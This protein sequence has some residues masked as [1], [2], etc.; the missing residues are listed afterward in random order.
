MVHL[1]TFAVLGVV[2]ATATATALVL[3]SA[4]GAQSSTA[5]D[6]PPH[7]VG[8]G[9]AHTYVTV[10]PDGTPTAIGVRLDAAG[11]YVVELGGLTMRE[12]S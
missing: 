3:G 4:A 8:N 10:G 6:G 1:R 11:Q 5:L 12:A 7:P 9:S 2:G